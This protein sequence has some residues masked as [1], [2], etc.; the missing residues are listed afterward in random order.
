LCGLAVIADGIYY[1]AGPNSGKHS[2]QFAGFT[3][4]ESR[5]LVLSDQPI[6]ELGVSVSPDQ[7]FVLYTQPDQS[8]SDLM[9]IENF[10]V[11]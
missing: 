5:P 7:R 3:T 4:G 11:Q 2:I 10:G 6:G 8:G 9:L 1:T